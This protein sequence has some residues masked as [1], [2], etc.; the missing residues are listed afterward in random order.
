MERREFG[1]QDGN[2]GI[3]LI[4]VEGGGTLW[5]ADSISLLCITVEIASAFKYILSLVRD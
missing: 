3:K 5:T 2:T 1:K 4:L